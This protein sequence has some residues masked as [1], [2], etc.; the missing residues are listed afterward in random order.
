MGAG[1]PSL[2]Q[3]L[4]RQTTKAEYRQRRNADRRRE[5]V[6]A[7]ARPSR[8]GRRRPHRSEYREVASQQG[9]FF[10]LRRGMAGS[11]H[12]R[13]IRPPAQACKLCGRQMYSVRAAGCCQRGIAIHQEPGTVTVAQ[14]DG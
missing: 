12:Q 14:L 4:V 2:I 10:Q 3:I 5:S 7:D 9:C 8:M 13:K 11:R 6:P 1:L